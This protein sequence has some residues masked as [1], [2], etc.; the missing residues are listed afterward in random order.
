M[1]LIEALP[2][3]PQIAVAD[4]KR[5]RLRGASAPANCRSEDV[6][7]FPLVVPELEFAL[8][9][10]RCVGHRPTMPET[11]ILQQ[12]EIGEAKPFKKCR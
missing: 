4:K 3:Q 5:R 6:R 2:P 11:S 12:L 10:F 9:G 7:I 1:L 8:A